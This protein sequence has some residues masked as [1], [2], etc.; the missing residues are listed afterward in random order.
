MA[1]K[2]K[3]VN[4]ELSWLAF[5]GRVLQEA[6]CPSV[7]LIERI[8]FLGIFSNNLD[9]FFRVRV[10]TLRR[11]VLVEKG[12]KKATGE[13]PRKILQKIQKEAVR[14]QAQFDATF[15]H[16]KECLAQEQIHFLDERTV[17]HEQSQYLQHLFETQIAGYLSPVMLRTAS[18]FPM[19]KDQSIY[20]GVRLSDT[21][22]QRRA[23]YAIVEVPTQHVPRFVVLPPD[24]DAQY[25][26]LLEDVIR[27]NLH[28]VFGLLPY[29]RFEAYI[30]KITRDA[31]LDMDN[32]ISEGLL[33]KLERSIGNRQKGAPVRLVYDADIAPDLL[34]RITTGIGIDTGENIIAG[35]RYHNFKDF[36]RFPDFGKP[37]LVN[38]PLIPAPKPLLDR[39]SSIFEAMAQRDFFLHYPYHSFAYF[40]RFLQEAAIDPKVRA[41]NITLYRVSADSKVV[42]AL[43]TAAQNG[44]QVTVVVE[45]RARFDEQANIYW[46]KQMQAAGIN[47]ISGVPGLKVHSKLALVVRKE[48]GKERLY[49]TVG[50]GNFHEGNA[51]I[52]TDLCLFTSNAKIT[53]EIHKAFEFMQYNYKSFAFRHLI[54]SPF[55]MRRRLYRL[56]DNEIANARAKKPA[57]IRC[58]LNHLVDTEIIEKLYEAGQAGVRIDL[59]VRGTCA[60][61]SGLKGLSENIAV[62]SIV[63]RLLEHSRIYIFANGGNDLYYISSAD[64]MTRNLDR[65]VEV[66]C[67]IFD[68]ALQAELRTIFDFAMR[69]NVKARQINEH[70][71]NTYCPRTK[72]QGDFRSQEETHNYYQKAAKLQ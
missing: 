41:I 24:N 44:K 7:P 4:R 54:V 61:V 65:R 64:W 58:K 22:G 25:I 32:D 52:Y 29:D 20:L 37:H 23:D 42:N 8:R 47:V 60:L 56:I 2:N 21:Q 6:Q 18:G 27:L 17:S 40:V 11:L 28:R 13:N 5:N 12:V 9:E 57:Y 59:V 30:F 68:R 53:N 46:S 48:S 16:L 3:I 70:Q 14:Y 38:Q 55:T 71:D 35:G 69:D 66:A 10:A 31:E 43:T 15:A 19:L 45:L 34:Q 49:A 1:T 39:A 72:K 62:R 50:T 36:M 33:R 63:D 26:I 67:P 51:N